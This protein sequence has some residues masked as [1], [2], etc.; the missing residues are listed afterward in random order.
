VPGK[1]PKGK[2]ADVS[3]LASGL[4]PLELSPIKVAPYLD[5][6]EFRVFPHI[7]ALTQCGELRAGV[8]FR[9]PEC[10]DLHTEVI[11]TLLTV[12]TLALTKAPSV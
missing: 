7:S 6:Q 5:L 4:T 8:L 12:V 10:K 11:T 1:P 3:S 2:V 9:L